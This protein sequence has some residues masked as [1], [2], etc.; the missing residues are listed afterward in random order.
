MFDL[1]DP[2]TV[3]GRTVPLAEGIEAAAALLAAAACPLIAG[4]R[5]DAAGA[6]AAAALARRLSAVLDHADSAAALRDLEA[7][8]RF[9][10]IVATPAAARA[11]ADLVLFIGDPPAALRAWLAAD[12]PPT[13]APPLGADAAP[14]R[15]LT[16]AAGE[17]LAARLG[18]LRA[19]L[20]GRRLPAPPDLAALA[21]TLRQARYGVIVWS[22]ALL[23]AL[24]VEMLAG[25]IEDL[26]ATTRFAGLPLPLPGN[27]AG[28]AQ[29]LG[30]ATGFPFR[31]GFRD[32]IARHDPWRYDAARLAASGEAD[33]ALWLDA[34]GEGP[35]AWAGQVKLVALAPQGAR[36]A[37][38]PAVALAVGRPGI[39]HAAALVHPL[40]AT[41]LAV[42]PPHPVAAR[43]A[44]A[45]A[46]PP[47][48]AALLGRIQQALPPC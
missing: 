28:V 31:I 10:W 20:K 17:D 1:A 35:P 21:E 23:D 7:M 4:L 26:N 38:P 24:A 43:G 5:T 41:L 8:R 33:A 42:T 39:D 22:A 19:C 14:R 6:A 11:S 30:A 34:F 46:A 40:A 3:G 44:S 2:A 27:A 9:G 15:V 25:L 48:A 29:A 18:T 36:F 37:A 32:G 12:R 16:L 45:D 47:A 13:L